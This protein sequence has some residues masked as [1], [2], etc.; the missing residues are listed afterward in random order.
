MASTT[1]L[2]ALRASLPVVAERAHDIADDF[3]RRLFATRPDLLRDQFNRGDLAQGRQQ[4]ELARTIVALAQAVLDAAPGSTRAAGGDRHRASSGGGPSGVDGDADAVGQ[5]GAPTLAPATPGEIVSRLAQRHAALGVTRDEYDLFE[6]HLGDA[7]AA[8]L[9]PRLTA[10]VADAWSAV[11]RQARDEMVTTVGAIYRQ[12]DLE[13]GE[14]WREAL[15]T[16][17]RVEA[18]DVVALTLV[19]ADSE[20]LPRYR[21]GQFA[22][23]Q[24]RLPDGA[25]QIRQYSLRGGH[26][27]QWRISARLLVGEPPAPDGEVSSHLMRELRVGDVVS[28][29]PPIGS[30]TID[31]LDDAPLLFVSAGI[32]CTPV[33]GMLDH[34]ARTEPDRVVTVLHF[35]RT[36]ERH[37][38]RVELEALVASMPNAT[39]RVSYTQGSL[40]ALSALAEAS[41][42][43]PGVYLD[44]IDLARVDLTASHRVFLCGPV[45]FMAIARA[46]LIGHGV[47]A[48]RVHYFVF[49]P[50]DG[51]VT[52][53]DTGQRG[54]G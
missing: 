45:P 15:V 20:T 35:E 49:G 32:G 37:A 43:G 6:R 22:S 39:L 24:V 30:L 47:D 52:G 7:F 5:A 13:P 42:D 25:R 9:G 23:V 4:R 21:A 14:E 36:P 46:A 26:D 50:D 54:L 11:Y 29:S 44:P 31:D 12:A 51:S 17:H 53:A 48:D 28:V 33:L 40:S 41:I 38:H 10:E 2:R 18:E 27:E 8:A 1:Q 34:L 16:E 3:Y 19:S